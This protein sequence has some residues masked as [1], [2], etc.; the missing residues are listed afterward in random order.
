MNP[1]LGVS[2]W[3]LAAISLFA[4]YDRFYVP[5]RAKRMFDR[6]V[7]QKDRVDPRALENSKY[8]SILC[9]A[10]G[11]VV[12][13]D[14]EEVR[15]NW[16]QIDEI[17]AY[18]AD[19]FTTDLICLVIISETQNQAVEIHEEMHGYYDARPYLEAHL[20]GYSEC[21]FSDVAFPAFVENRKMIWK[22]N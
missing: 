4:A 5:W 14:T 6:V 21:W 17:Y 11:I 12:R 22:K 18:K 3:V 2:L 16:D 13:R 15:L 10:K 8:G 1:I 19:L 7:Y 9:D 20:S